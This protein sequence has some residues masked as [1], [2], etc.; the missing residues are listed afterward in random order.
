ML[1]LK[2]NDQPHRNFKTPTW[3]HKLA[4][5]DPAGNLR[6]TA[7]RALI[8]G[9]TVMT[10]TDVLAQSHKRATPPPK[11]VVE[12]IWSRAGRGELLTEGGWTRASVFFSTSIPYPG[13][14]TIVIFSDHYGVNYSSVDG[15]NA[16]VEMEFMDMGRLDSALRYTP[17]ASAAAYKTSFSYRL[18]LVRCGS[19]TDAAD[20]K[21][22]LEQR[23]IPDCDGWQIQGDVGT[24]HDKP[25]TTVNGAIRYVLEMRAEA[26]DPSVRKN[27][28]ETIG[29]LLKLH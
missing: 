1:S 14:Q 12:E 19:K 17:P 28:D 4:C 9:L 27:A 2:R 16:V 10:G 7:V 25:W 21:R 18:S 8:L 6:S 29:K 5:G 13:N 22:R 23:E 20:G 15:S 24:M 3:M 26:K 11:E